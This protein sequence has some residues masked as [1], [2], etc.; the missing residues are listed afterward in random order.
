MVVSGE[1]YSPLNYHKT[2]RAQLAAAYSGASLEIVDYCPGAGSLPPEFESCPSDA[3]PLFHS[4]S[5]VTLFD[6]NAIAY[7]L[8]NKQLRGTFSSWVYICFRRRARIL[9]DSVG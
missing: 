9:C 6:A 1:I 3:A 7:F 5:G 8:G 2:L 4:K